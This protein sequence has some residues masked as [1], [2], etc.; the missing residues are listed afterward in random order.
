MNKVYAL[1]LDLQDDPQK[2]A[3][4]DEW[5]RMVW[6]EILDSIRQSGIEEMTIYRVHNRLFMLM[7]V[8]AG[9]SFE[10]KS[11]A[12]AASPKVQEWETLM[13]QF[14]QPLPFA[15]PGAKWVL[16]EKIFSLSDNNA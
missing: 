5:H 9:F 1:A 15:Q 2:I 14:Q 12:D 8:N 3:A 11:A 16:M 4:Y 10:E 7:E 6:P 13:W